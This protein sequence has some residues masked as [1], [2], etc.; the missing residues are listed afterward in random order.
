LVNF[1]V[2]TMQLLTGDRIAAWIAGKVKEAGCKGVVV[3]LSGGID[4]AV[5]AALCRKALGDNVLCAIMPCESSPRDEEDAVK[6]AAEFAI[7]T[8]TICLDSVYQSFPRVFSESSKLA[9]INLKPRLRMLTLYY[10]ANT[11][12]YLVV[13]TG[14]KS[15]IMVGYFTKYG[16]G[17]SDILPLGDLY[18][19]EVRELARELD[20][21]GE[22]IDKP[23][24]AGLRKNQTDEEELGIT[25]EKLDHALMAIETG[26]TEK[27]DS[28]ILAR[29]QSLIAGS[30]HKRLLPAI[31]KVSR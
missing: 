16:D 12:S 13:G 2:K 27:I 21:P 17:G 28:Q 23:P 14:N 29:V 11:Y 9:R 4:S 5:V 31:F 10:L 20:L 26:N 18:K 8:I 3:G 19:T 30:A 25:Y 22:L 7:R 6:L 24:S 1:L 15:E